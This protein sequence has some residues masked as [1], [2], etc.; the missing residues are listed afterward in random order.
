[1]PF[2]RVTVLSMNSSHIALVAAVAAA[3]SWTLKAIAIGTAGGLNLSPFEAP[4]FFAG[5]VSF[6]VGS[7]AT[8]VALARGTS[9]ARRVLAG[10]AALAVAFVTG[11]VATWLIS[12]AEPA[13]PSHWVWEEVGLWT[14]ALALLVVTLPLHTRRTTLTPAHG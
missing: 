8:G 13:G 3:A 12:L 1:V 11:T 5:L 2:R 4:L 9:V 6:V 7:I 10:A 14:M